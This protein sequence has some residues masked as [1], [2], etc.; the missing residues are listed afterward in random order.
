M[1]GLVGGVQAGLWSIRNE[2]LRLDPNGEKLREGKALFDE[3]RR[4]RS[5]GGGGC[6]AGTLEPREPAA[7]AE[8]KKTNSYGDPIE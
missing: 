5:G 8:P 4:S 2:A 1:F 6:P 7:K 3:L